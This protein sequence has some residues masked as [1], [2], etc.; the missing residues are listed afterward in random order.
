MDTVELFER[1]GLALAI[2]FLIGIERG[3]RERGEGEGG[4]TA[5]LRTFALS[6]LLGGLTA[7]LARELGVAIFAVVFLGFA[8]A[9][10]LFKWREAGKEN[11]YSVTTV[12]AAMLVFVLGGYAVV[13]HIALAAAAA[14]VTAALL[15]FKTMLHRWVAALSWPEIRSAIV[16]LAMTFVAL[17]L[18]PDR[19][20][21]PFGAFN[22]HAIWLLTV[23]IATVSFT[24]YVA[25]RLVGER[26]GLVLT[27][28]V[29]GLV[30]STAVTLDM[31]RRSRGPAADPKL[32]ASGACLSGAVMFG[33]ILVVAVL[34][35][36]RLWP[37]LAPAFVTAAAVAG[38]FG[39]AYLRAGR[40]PAK[41]QSTIIA[42]GNP[43]EFATVLRFGGLLALVM[44]LANAL[45]AWFGP[46]S[47]LWLAA[48]AGLADVDAVTL[49]MARGAGSTV[50]P[51]IA[52]LA[53]LVVAC[54]NSVSKS[55]LSVV[56]GSSAFA[57]RHV[58]AMLASVVLMALVYRA[59][60]PF[61]PAWP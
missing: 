51:T 55:V 17:P 42:L 16:L 43:F 39:F 31:A 20:F 23:M 21:G 4:R 35:E 58:A 52:V 60:L 10:T 1:L 40:S 45:Q 13:G 47:A 8:G 61:M 49:S 14:V 12:V 25:T 48:A 54:A 46:Q 27:A 24:G 38:L 29:G 34:I 3:W 36:Q 33:R 19:A 53:I 30:S 7:L 32:L 9:V 6:G 56:S 28:F 41:G 15:A 2:G 18:L 11:D 37:F 5:G 44:F 57:W 22:P 26:R 50:P 59:M